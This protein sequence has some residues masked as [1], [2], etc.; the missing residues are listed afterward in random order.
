[1]NAIDLG[2]GNTGGGFDPMPSKVP[3]RRHMEVAQDPLVEVGQRET[4]AALL[5]G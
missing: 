2:V 3:L 5:P 1:M 4:N